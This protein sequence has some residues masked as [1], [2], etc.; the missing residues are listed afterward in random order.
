MV[1]PNMVME[2]QHFVIFEYF[3]TFLACRLHSPAAW[4]AE[5]Q[6]PYSPYKITCQLAIDRNISFQCNIVHQ[7]HNGYMKTWVTHN[8]TDSIIGLF[9][10]KT[11]LNHCVFIAITYYSYRKIRLRADMLITQYWYSFVLKLWNISSPTTCIVGLYFCERFKGSVQDESR[12]VSVFTFNY[13]SKHKQFS[14]SCNANRTWIG[15]M[16][17][18]AWIEKW[19]NENVWKQNLLVSL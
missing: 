3:V 8:I 2:F 10:T 7:V 11:G 5:F 14:N 17:A 13:F 19:T 1:I 4:K 16:E 15:R 18:Y 6:Q 12:F 9:D